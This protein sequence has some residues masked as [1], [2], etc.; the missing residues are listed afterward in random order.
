MFTHYARNILLALFGVVATVALVSGASVGEGFALVY[1]VSPVD[2]TV[3]DWVD[4][5]KQC[6][7]FAL[8]SAALLALAWHSL[9]L[10]VS[11]RRGDLRIVWLILSALSIIAAGVICLFLLPSASR[12]GIWGY[13]FSLLNNAFAFWFSTVW[14]TPSELKYGPVLSIPVRARIR[15]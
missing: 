2:G 14:S 3:N 8:G 7:D 1:L 15:V 13:A 9:A 4:G 6:S 10:A 12:G 11:G 5:W